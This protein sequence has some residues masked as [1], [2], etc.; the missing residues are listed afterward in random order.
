[1]DTISKYNGKCFGDSK[2]DERNVEDEILIFLTVYEI[3]PYS[4]VRAFLKISKKEF[5]MIDRMLKML[6]YYRREGFDEKEDIKS[7]IE[8]EKFNVKNTVR[9]INII[10]KMMYERGKTNSHQL[11]YFPERK[12]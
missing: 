9:D 1:M 11:N 12:L 4:Y 2:I 8:S 7:Y 10:L 3:Q 5:E 6:T